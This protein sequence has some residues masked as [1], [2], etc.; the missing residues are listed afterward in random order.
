MAVNFDWLVGFV[1]RNADLASAQ[2]IGQLFG[3]SP[4]HRQVVLGQAAWFSTLAFELATRWLPLH[5]Q[6]WD[7]VPYAMVLTSAALLA[8]GAWRVA[9]RWAA[10]ITGVVIVCASPAALG[11]LF[12]LNDHSTTW[13]SMAL[14]AGLLVALYAR[15]GWMSTGATAAAVVA[16][17]AIVG[18]NVASDL[19]L[20]IAGVAPALLAV[21]VVWWLRPGPASVQ[22]GGWMC[23]TVA[24]AVF[25]DI[26]IRAL[27]HHENVI[28]Q[29][30]VNQLGLA[31]ASTLVS[32]FD[33]WWQSVMVLGN[34]NFFG[35]NLTLTSGL[36]II[37][38]VLS[39]VAVVAVVRFALAHVVATAGRSRALDDDADTSQARLAWCVFW[40]STVVALSLAFIF[41]SQPVDLDSTR[42]IVGILY[43]PAALL[44]LMARRGAA[45]RGIVAVGVSIFALTGLVSLIENQTFATSPGITYSS[46]GQLE[47]IAY[48]QRIT[49]GYADYWDAAA[50]TWSTDYRLKVFPVSGCGQNVCAYSLHVIS[51][52]YKG[53][54]GQRSFLLG[55]SPSP[56]M[57]K[58]SA[59]Y[60]IG[61]IAM[62][63]FPYDVGKYIAP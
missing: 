46:F 33:L 53:R 54:P 55:Q 7:A 48:D 15:P 11:W 1:Y 57:G 44:G 24:V 62:Y 43:G 18:V 3:G 38:A 28:G 4:A 50:I 35:D 12:A 60:Q 13:F 34:G 26:A 47:Q 51:S 41:S 10:M 23:A 59:T 36:Q 30:G 8:W 52:W 17:G 40:G 58:P 45:L 63:V 6:L 49:Y 39:L 27:M 42:Y 2:V 31:H 5:R 9:G 16:V 14:L 37:C 32:N 61:G 20:V 22:A 21:A 29:P 19:L 56:A 25:A